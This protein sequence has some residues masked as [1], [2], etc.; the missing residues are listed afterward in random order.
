LSLHV[1]DVR[2]AMWSAAAV[3]LAGTD[4]LTQLQWLRL[5]GQ[6]IG[7]E[8]VTALAG[9]PCLKGLVRLDLA[10]A[11]NPEVNENVEY[12][13]ALGSLARSPHWGPL[14]ELNLDD[15]A[16]PS[17]EALEA[18]LAAPNLATLR[19][20]TFRRE[21]VWAE[22]GAERGVEDDAARMLLRCR[23]L[24]ED[25]I[26]QLPEQNLSAGTRRRLQKRFGDGLTLLPEQTIYHDWD[27]WA[28]VS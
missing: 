19:V 18:L 4:R 10:G 12:A 23:H 2:D 22:H 1:C 11:C 26:V 5:R 27:D 9:W 8:G 7:A 15:G 21:W 6:E 3:A 24:A 17:L 14:R 20:L 13:A 28:S 25:V 16:V